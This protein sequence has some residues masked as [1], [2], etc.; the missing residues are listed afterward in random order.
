MVARAQHEFAGANHVQHRDSL[1]DADRE[2]DPGGGRLHDR[3]GGERGRDEDP[4]DVGAGRGHRVG[5]GVE[6]RD[7]VLVGTTLAGRHSGDDVGAE[8]AHL[9]GVE[10]PLASGDALDEHTAVPID[11]QAH[12]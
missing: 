2:P 3:V 5:D 11:Q 10:T 6:Y 9:R 7:A 4:G 12:V 8:G 1:G